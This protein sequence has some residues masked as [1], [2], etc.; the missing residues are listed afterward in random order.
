MKSKVKSEQVFLFDATTSIL[1]AFKA[2]YFD[3]KD[4]KV[5]V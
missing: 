2:F 1:P 4:K 5:L 3:N